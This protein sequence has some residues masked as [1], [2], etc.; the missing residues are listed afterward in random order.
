MKNLEKFNN[1]IQIMS[2]LRGPNGCNWDKEQDHNSIKNN[3]IE[4]A[5]E[6]LEAIDEK[7]PDK[8]KEELGDLL[9]QIIFHSQMAKEE[10]Q[11]D[12]YDVIDVLSQKLV[13]RHPHV[14]GESNAK[15]SKEIIKQW[16]NIKKEENDKQHRKSITD[17][18]PKHLPSILKAVKIQKKVSKVGFDW[19]HV[20]DVINK[21]QEELDE[22]KQAHNEKQA[23]AAI[24]E[25][26]G[27]LL[28]ASINL[29]RFLDIC[30]DDAL[31]GTITKF[32]KRFKYIE[33]NLNKPLETA[34]SEELEALWEQ[35]KKKS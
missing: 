31:S 1:L 35:A 26:I 9:L 20:D 2:N 28:F 33:V 15:T 25:E 14:F 11:F 17:G 13:R 27:D 21:I 34:S 10:K 3:L 7:N 16:E 19:E 22:V 24:K 18:I 30:P 8:M 5:Y 6:L 29:A 12:I 23:L 4:E 32:Q